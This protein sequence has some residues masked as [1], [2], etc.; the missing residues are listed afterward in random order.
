MEI[1]RELALGADGDLDADGGAA[2]VFLDVG[3]GTLKVGA[4]AVELVDDDG[5]GQLEIVDDA[6]YL[7]G[8]HFD[9]GHAIHQH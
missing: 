9:A 7:F 3:E 6:S 8:L 2:E 5:A 4:F 1:D